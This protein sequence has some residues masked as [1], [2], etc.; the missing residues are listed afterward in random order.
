MR[1]FNQ[2]LGPKSRSDETN[3]RKRR[4]ERCC[5]GNGFVIM[6]SVHEILKTT[7]HL[8]DIFFKLGTNFHQSL[9]ERSNL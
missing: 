4:L 2:L 5:D 8:L 7:V 3:S 9:K 6:I 1:F